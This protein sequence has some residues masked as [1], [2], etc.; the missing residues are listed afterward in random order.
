MFTSRRLLTPS[1]ATALIVGFATLGA[2]LAA[3]AATSSPTTSSVLK[4]SQAAIDKQTSVHVAV[5]S[6]SGKVKSNVVAD[7]G[8]TS[9]TE[10]FVSGTKRITITVTPTYAYLNGNAAGLTTLM[11]LS[12][13]EQKVVGNDWIAMKAGTTQYTSFKSNLTISAFQGLLPV[14]KGTVLSFSSDSSK[15]YQLKWTT[16]ATTSTPKSTNV[17]TISSGSLPLPLKEVITNS[18]GGATTSFS[19]WG[20]TV[21]VPVPPT[22][23]TIAYA[24]VVGS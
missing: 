5:T 19:K 23:S 14:A 21:R 10:T 15:N 6:T 12:A 7:M 13:K 17:L 2:P 9:G 3:Q 1:L 16:V 8:P 24:K 18:T 11:G 22:S 4:A 20:E